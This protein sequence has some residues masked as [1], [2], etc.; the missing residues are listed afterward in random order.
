MIT[1]V[2]VDAESR[3]QILDI[4]E[5]GFGTHDG[6]YPIEWSGNCCIVG[7]NI[8]ELVAEEA[9]KRGIGIQDGKGY[10]R[11]GG[12]KVKFCFGDELFDVPE[13]EAFSWV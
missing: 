4:I 5:D 7:L 11:H 13:K 3:Q 9:R 6:W 1:I 8:G 2:Y 12:S 10:R